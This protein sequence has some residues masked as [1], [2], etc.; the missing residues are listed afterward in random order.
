[1]ERIDLVLVEANRGRVATQ[2]ALQELRQRL[3]KAEQALRER[4]G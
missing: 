4:S 3:E 1:M 2:G